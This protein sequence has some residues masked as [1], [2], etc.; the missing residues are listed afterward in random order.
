[1]L[2]AGARARADARATRAQ[3]LT[4]FKTRA[5]AELAN[6]GLP[7]LREVAWIMPGSAAGLCGY[8]DK[9]KE[10]LGL[11][12]ASKLHLDN[13]AAAVC[14]GAALYSHMLAHHTLVDASPAGDA[15]APLHVYMVDATPLGVSWLGRERRVD[16]NTGKV[17]MT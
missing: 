4:R 1:M 16:E 5:E 8:E 14:Q 15:K 13:P 12:A 10:V 7:S 17:T 9:C 11:T 3:V 2:R 6:E